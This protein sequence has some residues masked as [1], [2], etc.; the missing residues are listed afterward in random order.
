[1]HACVCLPFRI[2]RHANVFPLYPLGIQFMSPPANL[3]TLPYD[4]G[5]NCQ[6]NACTIDPPPRPAGENET[7]RNLF[8]NQGEVAGE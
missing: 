3:S 8:G 1:M 5:K 7:Q 2:A 6:V 4:L